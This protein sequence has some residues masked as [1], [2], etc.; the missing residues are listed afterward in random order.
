MVLYMLYFFFFFWPGKDLKVP[1]YIK[2]DK[3]LLKMLSP[4]CCWAPVI[5]SLLRNQ[6]R[7]ATYICHTCGI[8]WIR[9]PLYMQHHMMTWRRTTHR[10]FVGAYFPAF[11]LWSD[12][13]KYTYLKLTVCRKLFKYLK[14]RTTC[15]FPGESRLTVV[16]RVAKSYSAR[17]SINTCGTI[18]V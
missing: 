17:P 9:T 11:S 16:S 7:D 1:P 6:G 13:R 4:A 2:C 18:Y 15:S 10:A 14:L 5:Y 12:A 8:D 3:L